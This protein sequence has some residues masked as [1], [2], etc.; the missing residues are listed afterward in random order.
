MTGSVVARRYAQAL[1]DIVSQRDTQY[2]EETGSSLSSL[3]MVTQESLELRRL[4][5]NPVFT[6]EEKKKVI[7]SLAEQFHISAVVR[8]FCYLL[9]EKHR[10][11]LLEVIFAEFQRLADKQKGLLRGEVITAFTLTEE[12]QQSLSGKLEKQIGHSLILKFSVDAGLLGGMILKVGDKILDASLKTQLS[13][14]EDTIK[15]GD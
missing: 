1:F 4:F 11:N 13:L 8:N 7:A 3:S 15:R 10:L 12:K 6:S 9:A 5:A 2:V 14:L